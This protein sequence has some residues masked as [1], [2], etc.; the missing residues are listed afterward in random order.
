MAITSNILLTLGSD[1]GNISI[2]EDYNSYGTALR[3]GLPPSSFTSGTGYNLTG[4]NDNSTTLK[5][6]SNSAGCTNE[7]FL[8][9]GASGKYMAAVFGGVGTNAYIVLS[10]DYGGNFERWTIGAPVLSTGYFFVPNTLNM[11]ASGQTGVVAAYNN[12]SPVIYTLKNYYTAH[13]VF[14]PP[15]SFQP[16]ASAVS[17][18]GVYMVVVGTGYMYLSSDAGANWILVGP[19]ASYTGVAISVDGK[20][21]TASTTST[22]SVYRSE[23]Y[24]VDWTSVGYGSDSMAITGLKMSSSGKVQIFV[25]KSSLVNSVQGKI[26]VNYGVSW[27]VINSLPL[28]ALNGVDLTSDGRIAITYL[29]GSWYKITINTT[30]GTS[31]LA[32]YSSPISGAGINAM[33]IDSTGEVLLATLLNNP[34][35]VSGNGGAGW[36]QKIGIANNLTGAAI[37]KL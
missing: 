18:N 9:I 14:T 12:S 13:S 24:G 19:A 17:G 25:G 31:T 16:K 6:K 10:K 3:T 22:T 27:V 28:N 32:A 11:S 1:V 23:N 29:L 7:A 35:V 33:S 30:T 37:N 8:K 21:I 2:Y 15:V 20:Y 26:S 36:S 5:I 4:I 34:T